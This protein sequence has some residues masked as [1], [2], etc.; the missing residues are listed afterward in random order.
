LS[1][2][3]TFKYTICPDA[4]ALISCASCADTC[5]DPE[6]ELVITPFW[7]AA[8]T[9]LFSEE[10]LVTKRSAKKIDNKT[11]ANPTAKINLC[12]EKSFGIALKIFILFLNFTGKY[13][14]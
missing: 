11:I 6:T 14:D 13:P 10:L 2:G 9:Y 12:L 7:T 5:P 4:L 3:F 8:K 1:P